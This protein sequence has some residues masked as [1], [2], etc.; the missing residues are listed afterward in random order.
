VIFAARRQIVFLARADIFRKKLTAA[1]LRFIR[2]LPV[3]RIRDGYNTLGQNQE[4]FDEVIIALRQ[5]ISVGIFP[6]GGHFASKELRP[7]KKGIARMAFQAEKESQFALGLQIVPVGLDYSDYHRAG[8]DLVVTFGQPLSVADYKEHFMQNEAVG[9]NRLLTDLADAMRS[10]LA[11]PPPK[12]PKATTRWRQW[13]GR[14]AQ[15]ITSI[16]LFPFALY[17]LL[18]NLTP[19]SLANRLAAKAEDPHFISSFRFGAGFLLFNLWYLLMTI[20]AILLL[21]STWL[22]VAF[23]LSMPVSAIMA[24]YYFQC[25]KHKSVHKSA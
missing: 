16:L 24:F 7:L 12:P 2:I 17:G 9:M 18:L 25:R 13:A 6:E 1:L 3:Y 14:I 20:L 8:A 23:L 21:P 15:S 4:T 22:I 19:A 10:A 11:D 5:N